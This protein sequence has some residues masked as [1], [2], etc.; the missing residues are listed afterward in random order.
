M[1]VLPYFLM[2]KELGMLD[3]RSAL[4][5]INLSI[6]LPYAVWMIKGFIDDADLSVR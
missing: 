3:T 2:F 6:V 1:V 4:V 5:L